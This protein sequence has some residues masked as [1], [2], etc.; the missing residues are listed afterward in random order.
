MPLEPPLI[1]LHNVAKRFDNDNAKAGEDFTYVKDI[2]PFV[3]GLL[4]K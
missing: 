4:A 3:D 2:V 1:S